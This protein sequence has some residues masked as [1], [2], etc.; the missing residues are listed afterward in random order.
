[1]PW[2]HWHTS[3]KKTWNSCKISDLPA[4][5]T[6]CSTRRSGSDLNSAWPASSS[7]SYKHPSMMRVMKRHN[8]KLRTCC[9]FGKAFVLQGGRTIFATSKSSGVERLSMFLY[10]LCFYIRSN[11]TFLREIVLSTIV[12]VRTLESFCYVACERWNWFV[13]RPT[14]LS[15][16]FWLQSIDAMVSRVAHGVVISHYVVFAFVSSSSS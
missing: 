8:C 13:L 15:F 5:G 3:S 12:V 11:V 2:F 14:T 9:S 1:M 16:M 6:L 4:P 10:G 7:S